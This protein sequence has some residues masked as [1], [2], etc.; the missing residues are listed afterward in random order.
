MTSTYYELDDDELTALNQKGLAYFSAQI[1]ARS[2]AL[3]PSP[4]KDKRG[5][6]VY[7]P[8]KWPSSVRIMDL[9]KAAQR[10]L[11]AKQV[12][13]AELQDLIAQA[14]TR[15]PKA[16]TLYGTPLAQIEAV[17][18]GHKI[19]KRLAL[20]DEVKRFDQDFE[21]LTDQ[22]KTYQGLVSPRDANARAYLTQPEYEAL[23]V[24][25][26][27]PAYG[28][29][30]LTIAQSALAQDVQRDRFREL[31]FQ[32][33]ATSE[34][35]ELSIR[36]VHDL[37]YRRRLKTALRSNPI[38]KEIWAY[39]KK[40]EV[41]ISIFETENGEAPS[42]L[43]WINPENP[44]HLFVMREPNI[45]EVAKTVV[46]ETTHLMD[47]TD[48]N[49]FAPIEDA[50]PE[51]EAVYNLAQTSLTEALAYSMESTFETATDL[52]HQ[53]V[54]SK[55]YIESFMSFLDSP[56]I[57]SSYQSFLLTPALHQVVR[58]GRLREELAQTK[59]LDA[60]VLWDRLTFGGKGPFAGTDTGA[61]TKESV[62]DLAIERI[63]SLTN[64]SDRTPLAAP[65]KP[66]SNVGT[67]HKKGI[68]LF[69]KA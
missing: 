43:G 62:R 36:P 67:I 3:P 12:D 27:D 60:N 22:L 41:D 13:I 48:Y 23:T 20:L 8:A 68:G 33:A 52:P 57:T 63:S 16:P 69:S 18:K 53:P 4:V 64:L 59:I 6:S 1:A 49:L 28:K 46:H 17:L 42:E 21:T 34:S 55:A 66:S 31:L 54:T 58:E 44:S 45:W 9:P 51:K 61:Y 19:G 35:A 26:Q 24:T 56:M 7:D 2:N 10:L 40:S 25:T 14:K 38:G 32:N 15:N 29:E 65:A 37:S 11:N 30:L 50:T 47:I 39:L 5:R